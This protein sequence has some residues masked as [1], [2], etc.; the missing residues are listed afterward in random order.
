MNKI[1]LTSE[2]YYDRTTDWPYQS[3]SKFK[4]FMACEAA[5]LAELKG[6]WVPERD[7]TAFLVGNYL[8]SHFESSEAHESFVE[9]NKS[10]IIASTG[11]NKGKPKAAF[12]QADTMIE[13]LE[14]SQSF[15]AFYQGGKEAIVTGKIDGIQWKGKIDC[16]NLDRGYFVDLKTVDDIHKKHWNVADHS[17]V[18]FVEDRLYHYQMAI[19]QE[20]IKQ[21]YGVTCHPYIVAISKQK[22]PD[23]LPIFIP[24]YRLEEAMTDIIARQPHIEAVKNGLEKPKRCERC[25][26][27]RATK[28]F[29]EIVS[30]DD[31]ID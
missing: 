7:P 26:Y 10:T 27:C 16:L 3:F 14:S 1:H 6:E 24:A 28:T 30:M 9:A 20:L 11:K 4:D 2:N 15:E 12:Q 19:Y 13:K 22:A 8:H 18:S 5:A 31:L 17:W 29:G 25:E 21:T 23:M